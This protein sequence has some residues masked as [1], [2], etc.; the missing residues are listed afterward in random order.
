[1]QQHQLDQ[2]KA[3]TMAEQLKDKESMLKKTKL[4]D[5]SNIKAEDR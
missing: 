5:G 4:G 2:P 1:M 3:I